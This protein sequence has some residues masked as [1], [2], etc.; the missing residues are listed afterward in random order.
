MNLSWR[1]HSCRASSNAFW[2]GDIFLIQPNEWK[3]QFQHFSH[4]CTLNPV[5]LSAHTGV[6][7]VDMEGVKQTFLLIS[8]LLPVA[9]FFRFQRWFLLVDC[10]FFVSF[11][12]GILFYP[13]SL[14]LFSPSYNSLAHTPSLSLAE[15]KFCWYHHQNCGL[16]ATRESGN[17]LG[18]CSDARGWTK[19]S[20]E[21]PEDGESWADGVEVKTL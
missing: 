18:S 7:I 16:I 10:S 17:R 15:F 3:I 8:V 11:L 19:A 20:A 14:S 4:S 6:W 9:T 13:L 2:Y 12:P 5:P 1:G 21:Q